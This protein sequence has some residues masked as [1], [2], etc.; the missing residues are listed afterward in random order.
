MLAA[1]GG[2]GG[3]TQT[4]TIPPVITLNGEAV[5]EILTLIVESVF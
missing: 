3:K 1:C 4:D 2:S 5:I